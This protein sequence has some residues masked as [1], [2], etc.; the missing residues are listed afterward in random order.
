MNRPDLSLVGRL[1]VVAIILLTAGAYL[2]W[3]RRLGVGTLNE[4]G[5]A[6][7]ELGLTPEKLVVLL[8]VVGLV[9][10]RVADSPPRVEAALLALWGLVC[11]L[12]PAYRLSQAPTR[13]D[14]A[15]GLYLGA[16]AGLVLSAAA[17]ARYLSTAERT[18]G[19]SVDT[20]S[21]TD[22]ATD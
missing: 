14:P 21:T 20:A 3:M 7:A 5:P 12:L 6:I 13:F 1:V 8:P 11:A 15:G 4:P 2:P 18:V 17:M 19:D 10:F 16:I 9:A 22:R